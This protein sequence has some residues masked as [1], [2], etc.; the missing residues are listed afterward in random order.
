MKTV[1]ALSSLRAKSL[2]LL[3]L[4][5]LT[6]FCCAENASSL[7]VTQEDVME[8]FEALKADAHKLP[9]KE[10]RLRLNSLRKLRGQLNPPP[11]RQ[12]K[13]DHVVVLLMENHGFD[14]MLGCMD[15]P[16]A[17]GI[18][19]ETGHSIPVDPSDPTKGNVTM[20]CG[21]AKYVCP[22]GPGYGLFS[23]KFAPG[24]N[25]H[26][27]PYDEQSD[28]NSYANGATG[29]TT[30]TAY[31]PDQIP[32]KASVAKH[33]G[34]F[35]RYYTSVPS[36]SSPNHL[37]IQSATSCGIIDNIV[38]TKCGGKTATFPQMTIY[39]SMYVN[40]ISFSIFMNSTCGIDG[41]PAC[42]G[43][44]PTS[45]DA[46]STINA[47][48]VGMSGV[49]RYKSRFMSQQ[50]FYEG[51][52]NGTLPAL[53][54]MLPPM[55]A[56]D[57]PC[58]DIAKGERLLKDVYEALRASPKWNKTLFFVVYDDDGGY[59]DHVV[60]PFEGVP[61]D[62][63]PCHITD[64]CEGSQKFDFRRLGLRSTAMLIS[65]LVPKGAVFQEPRQGPTNTSQFDH[66]SVPATLKNLFNLTGFLTKRDEWAGSFDEL[67][68]D[69]PRADAPMHLPEAPKPAKPWGPVPNGSDTTSSLAPQHCSRV[70]RA[71]LGPA[72][73]TQKQRNAIRL[74]SN[75]ENE[76]LPD[77]D[78]MDVATADAWIRRVWGSWIA[79][80]DPWE[81]EL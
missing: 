69:E 81:E 59:Y 7:V 20:K 9:E 61:S 53:S 15:L 34:V 57:H 67:L 76:K 23:S 66:T 54:W 33:F 19:T 32:V 14:Q 39:D 4:L 6:F 40:N 52:A 30:M 79:R 43:V 12:D 16:G 65:P 64:Q 3:L 25:T 21:T 36:A 1:V 56:C 35:N 72:V 47:P 8:A 31:S 41:H 28:G 29:G 17:D 37:M 26:T 46:G 42:H 71:C 80:D 44:D 49:G 51:A 2:V 63:A 38:Y 74:F 70:A 58:Y 78:A 18:S 75:L 62:D 27:Y 60:P 73:S 13:V 22:S 55:E 68:L 5:L 50:F 24:A 45:P 10:M 11:P 48:D 77:V